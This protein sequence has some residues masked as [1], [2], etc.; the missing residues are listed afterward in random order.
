MLGRDLNLAS[1]SCIDS[2]HV[3]FG[4][5][6]PLQNIRS[7]FLPKKLKPFFQIKEPGP[8]LKK[9]LA[10]VCEI[11]TVG[12]VSLSTSLFSGIVIPFMW[13]WFFLI[14][15]Y[16]LRSL[17]LCFGSG[18]PVPLRPG[19]LIFVWT[20]FNK[21]G[22]IYGKEID[23]R[24]KKCG[25]WRGQKTHELPQHSVWVSLRMSSYIIVM[26]NTLCTRFIWLFVVRFEFE[27]R[28]FGTAV[29]LVKSQELALLSRRYSSVKTGHFRSK[30]V[31][32]V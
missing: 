14:C 18:P 30:K 28:R 1:H 6:R 24:A 20:P 11:M 31:K 16:F 9:T 21:L 12:L 2:S 4:S 15:T 8:D 27:K 13:I 5:K 3:L 32:M 22:R 19:T 29:R 17:M 7:L 23:E 26:R 25:K 10:I